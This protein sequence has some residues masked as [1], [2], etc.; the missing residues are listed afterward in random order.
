MEHGIIYFESTYIFFEI[1]T[2]HRYFREVSNKRIGHYT[3]A[4][5]RW[6]IAAIFQIDAQAKTQQSSS[7]LQMK[8][9]DLSLAIILPSHLFM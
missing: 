6:I 2:L 1:V 8:Y 9:N 3:L 7:L 4:R 5:T